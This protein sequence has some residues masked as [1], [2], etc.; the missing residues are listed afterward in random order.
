MGGAGVRIT[1][2]V[3]GHT[4]RYGYGY[5]GWVEGEGTPNVVKAE[6]K[7]EEYIIWAQRQSIKY[8]LS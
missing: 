1:G 5:I 7:K 4:C 8:R 6:V 3:Q 2:G